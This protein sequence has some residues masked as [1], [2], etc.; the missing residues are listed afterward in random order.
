MNCDAT[1]AYGAE[2]TIAGRKPRC[3]G[4]DGAIRDALS[5]GCSDTTTSMIS[6]PPTVIEQDLTACWQTMYCWKIPARI[7]R[8]LWRS[9]HQLLQAIRRHAGLLDPVRFPFSRSF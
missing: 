7:W 4:R 6:A 1:N 5:T 9:Y 2:R 3:C 8:R